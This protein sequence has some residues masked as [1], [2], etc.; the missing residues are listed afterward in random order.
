MQFS[1]K[2]Y[3]RNHGFSPCVLVCLVFIASVCHPPDIVGNS[4]SN[5]C[6]KTYFSTIHN[7]FLFSFLESTSW[8]AQGKII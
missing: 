3:Y 1:P 5:K 8:F 7:S 6:H 2:R 4:A